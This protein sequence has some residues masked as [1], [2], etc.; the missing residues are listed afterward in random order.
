MHKRAQL[1]QSPGLKHPTAIVHG[2]SAENLMPNINKKKLY[3]NVSIV[4]SSEEEDSTQLNFNQ[5]S[6]LKKQLSVKPL[7]M[8]KSE[9]IPVVP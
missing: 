2:S 4:E 5:R 6:Q 1:R 3:K 9:I 7:Q 8:K